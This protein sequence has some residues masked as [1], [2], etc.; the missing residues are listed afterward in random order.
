MDVM[1]AL[2]Y[3]LQLYSAVPKQV[4]AEREQLVRELRALLKSVGGRATG[5][6]AAG[7]IRGGNKSIGRP[8][9]GQLTLLASAAVGFGAI[10]IAGGWAMAGR[11]SHP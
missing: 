6:A 10:C 2:D 3:H 9:R 7:A 11:G 1:I 4:A 5:A 8:W